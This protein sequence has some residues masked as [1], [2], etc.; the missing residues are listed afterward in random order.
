[1]NPLYSYIN[2]R[3]GNLGKATEMTFA[4]SKFLTQEKFNVIESEIGFIIYK[5]EGDACIVNDIYTKKDHRKTKG[6]W[7]LFQQLKDIV[8][9]N[10]SCAVMVGFSEFDGQGQEHGKG[11]MKAAGFVKVGQDETREIYMRGTH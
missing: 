3:Y 2:E 7:K 11:A 4:Y 5:F 10:P 8:Q 1:M 9:S 6:A